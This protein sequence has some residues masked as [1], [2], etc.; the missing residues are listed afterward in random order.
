MLSNFY[1]YVVT[2]K[3]PIIRLMMKITIVRFKR[4]EAKF[5]KHC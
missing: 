3:H 5:I 1:I 4:N 2:M